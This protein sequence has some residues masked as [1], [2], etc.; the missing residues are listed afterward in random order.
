[1][2]EQLAASVHDPAALAE[3]RA[4][5]LEEIGARCLAAQQMAAEV[6]E[7]AAVALATAERRLQ[8]ARA[9]QADFRRAVQ[10]AEQIRSELHWSA[11]SLSPAR[12]GG[13]VDAHGVSGITAW[14]DQLRPDAD[15]T[16]VAARDGRP[17]A[18]AAAAP[19]G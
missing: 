2:D 13:I 16:A 5:R 11:G 8:R 4:R 9:N 1:M 7:R 17:L 18:R 19:R 10:R 12:N 14:P 3:A 6:L 15:G